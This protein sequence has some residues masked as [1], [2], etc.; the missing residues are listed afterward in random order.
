[1]K[2]MV[3]ALSLARLLLAAEAPQSFTGVITDTMCGAK[4]DMMKG[5]PDDECVKMCVKGSSQYALYDGKDVWKLSDQ[6]KASQFPAEK[7]L[8]TG[9]VSPDEK[10]IKVVSIERVK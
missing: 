9:T 6:K 10:A 4:H 1:M 7:V 8:V 3:V 2:I 5:T